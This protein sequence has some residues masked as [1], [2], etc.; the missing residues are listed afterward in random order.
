RRIRDEDTACY[1][2]L[3][4]KERVI[5]EDIDLDPGYGPYRASAVAAG[6]RAVQATPLFSADGAPLGIL[7]TYFVSHHRPTEHQLRLTDLFARQAAAMIE[8]QRVEATLRR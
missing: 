2:A 3:R 4:K 6:Y 1:R 8:R 5:I 7:S